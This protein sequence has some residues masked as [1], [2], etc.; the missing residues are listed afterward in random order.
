MSD[1]KPM[2]AE[3]LAEARRLEEAATRGPWEWSGERG[4]LF[5]PPR[6]DDYGSGP[7]E[8]RDS[9]VITD[10]GYYPP[11][12]SDRAFI[13][14]SRVLVPRLLA[15]VE[16]LTRERDALTERVRLLTLANEMSGAIMAENGQL[17]ARI[18][19]LEADLGDAQ[20][21][22]RNAD[23]VLTETAQER[24]AARAEA[25]T[26]RAR[27]AEYEQAIA[28][29][30]SRV[31]D[32]TLR[33]DLPHRVWADLCHLHTDTRT[34]INSNTGAPSQFVTAAT[35]ALRNPDSACACAPPPAKHLPDCPWFAID[36]NTGS[37]EPK[38][39]GHG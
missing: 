18:T 3:E 28:S 26:L 24:D 31:C 23:E 9:I 39:E 13:A 5:G 37:E 35:A 19:H 27:V 34:L 6:T 30:D 32:L 38:G 14:A 1:A 12:A 29:I 20:E 16:R 4:D 17:S 8:V 7:E 25:E 11:R 33:P 2:T 21:S 36:S 22:M 15:E 10:G